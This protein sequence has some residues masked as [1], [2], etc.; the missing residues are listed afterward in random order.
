VIIGTLVGV[1]EVFFNLK[2]IHDLIKQERLQTLIESLKKIADVHIKTAIEEL[3]AMQHST[4]PEHE[5]NRAI[6]Q[7]KL[8]ANSLMET[9]ERRP[10]LRRL[11][12]AETEKQNRKEVSLQ[13]TSC[14][15]TVAGLYHS[16]QNTPLAKKYVAKA[17]EAFEGYAVIRQAELQ[18]RIAGKFVG[19]WANDQIGQSF[20]YSHKEAE[21][22]A[23]KRRFGVSS[24][25][26]VF[27][28]LAKQEM[29]KVRA[30]LF[31]WLEQL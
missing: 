30:Q 29:N 19:T 15:L 26:A 1:V 16:Q 13:I 14:Y 22:A 31:G 7:L 3:G 28:Q 10:I 17:K 8:A 4:Q 5:C 23:Y 25:Q 27:W 18:S 20:I 12:A 11:M 24:N 9:Q 6:G 2:D 21:L